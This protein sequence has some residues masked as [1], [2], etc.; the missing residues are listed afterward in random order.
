MSGSQQTSAL[1]LLHS[2]TQVFTDS[3]STFWIF[4]SCA[5]AVNPGRCGADVP[6]GSASGRR[7]PRPGRTS[8]LRGA[9]ENIVLRSDVKIIVVIYP[10][11]TRQIGCVLFS[12]FQF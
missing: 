3:T 8:S 2:A 5:L 9:V 12:P 4:L 6:G 7:V 1:L 11:V 10:V